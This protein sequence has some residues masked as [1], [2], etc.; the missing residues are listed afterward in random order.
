MLGGA[1]ELSGEVSAALQSY[2]TA[3]GLAA[4]KKDT[5]LEAVAKVR[6]AMLMQTAPMGA[7]ATPRPTP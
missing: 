1:Q 2:S 6:M 3:A 5:Q 7:S 4:A